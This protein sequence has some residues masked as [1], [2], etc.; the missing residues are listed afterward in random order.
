MLFI[1]Y[2]DLFVYCMC[3]SLRIWYCVLFVIH[4]G[5]P[6]QSFVW[7]G[8]VCAL[9]FD[10]DW[11]GNIKWR[12][13]S[14]G[15]KSPGVSFRVSRGKNRSSWSNFVC[16]RKKYVEPVKILVVCQSPSPS[17]PL[18]HHYRIR[19]AGRSRFDR[20]HTGFEWHCVLQSHA[21]HCTLMYCS[22]TH[23]F[24]D[25]VYCRARQN[26]VH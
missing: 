22:V 23:S 12:L 11:R 20:C 16:P 13:H 26:I 6:G 25:I 10:D 14:A 21:K 19:R 5:V 1:I 18:L 9:A 15:M 2:L 7:P 3:W 4:H 24:Y 17:P 8:W